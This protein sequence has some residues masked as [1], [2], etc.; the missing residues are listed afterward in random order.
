MRHHRLE[1]GSDTVH[2]GFFDAALP[3]VL[4]IASGDR[5]TIST[6][7]G[8]ADVNPPPPLVV[9]TALRAV[10]E[11]VPNRLPGH[12]CTGPVAVEGARAG[13]VLEVAIQAIEL[14]YDW[15]Y[16]YAAP[17]KGALPYEVEERHLIHLPLD[18]ESG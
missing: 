7:S 15:G 1:A 14:H 5:V 2:W 9:P 3:P 18:R 12:M 13:G 17:L 11:H 10:Q 6:V 4:T 16:T 8:G